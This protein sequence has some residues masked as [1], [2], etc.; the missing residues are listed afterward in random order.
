MFKKK[1]R[2]SKINLREKNIKVKTLDRYWAIAVK[3]RDNWKCV[4]CGNNKRDELEAH[5]IR[6]RKHSEVKFD[7]DDGVTLC[8]P[9]KGCS[10]HYKA[11][12]SYEMKEWIK[13]YIGRKKYEELDR[14]SY[15][16]KK[17]SSLEK[18]DLLRNFKEYLKENE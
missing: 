17:W 3:T 4:Y 11:H 8:K 15:Q 6:A 13:D 1:K 9:Y 14:R 2:K 7:L 12:H 5:H 16:V 10:G 18:R